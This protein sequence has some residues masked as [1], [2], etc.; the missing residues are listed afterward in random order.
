MSWRASSHFSQ[1]VYFCFYYDRLCGLVVRVPGYRSRGPGLVPV[2]TRFSEKSWGP[3]SLVS[4]IEGLLGIKISDSGPESREY[5][6]RDLL[7]WPIFAK[8]GSN[9]AEKRRSL[10]RYSSLADSSHE[11]SLDSYIYIY[12]YIAF[13]L[14]CP[15]TAFT[16][17]CLAFQSHFLSS[18]TLL[19]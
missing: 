5:G 16:P 12:I 19:F 9:F 6:R 15:D 2:A 7:R 11:F 18:I 14:M 10:D 1:T 8:V 13:S 4:A 3:L 17:M